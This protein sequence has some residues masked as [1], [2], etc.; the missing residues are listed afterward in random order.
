MLRDK[1]VEVSFILV[2]FDNGV[3]RQCQEMYLVM[4]LVLVRKPSK[5]CEYQV[6]IEVEVIEFVDMAT[7]NDSMRRHFVE[8]SD[9]R[10]RA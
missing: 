9:I 2:T 1:S 8:E 5:W 7:R 6:A 10:W 4:V 3:M